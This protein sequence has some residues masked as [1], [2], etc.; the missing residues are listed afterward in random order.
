MEKMNG[1]SMN[2]EL[3]NIEKIGEIFP[4]VVTE[5]KVDFDILRTMLGEEVDTSKE[6]YQF[7]WNGKTESI[8]IA[9]APSSATLRPCRERS[10][11][12]DTTEN[13]YIEGDNLETL[14]QLQKTFFGKIKLIYIDPPYNTGN[15]FVYKDDFKDTIENYKEQTNQKYSSNAETS[16]RYHSDWL[17]MM[18]PR[19]ILARNLLTVD[20][21]IFIS[22]NDKELHNL[23]KM[24]EDIFGANNEVATLIWDKNHSAQAGIYKVYHE[25]V[26]VYARD[27]S[28][29]SKSKA[30]NSDVFEAGAMKKVS[31]RHPASEFTFPAGTRFDAP[32]GTIIEGE[33]GETEKVIITKGRLIA[34]NGVLKENVTL[35]AGFTQANQMRQFF[36]G[37]RDSLTDTQ[38][39]KIVEFYFNATG[40][41][42]VV[43]ERGV[44]TPQTTCKFGTQGAASTALAELFGLDETPF[45]SPKPVQMIKD[46]IGRFTNEQDIIID[47][48]SGSATTAHAVMELCM[49]KEE[50]RK[51]ILIQLPE[52][53]VKAREV[54]QKDAVRPIETA[55]GYLKAKKMELNLC[56]IGEERIRRAGEAIKKEWQQQKEKKGL[57]PG[58]A[59]P[60]DIGFKVFKLDSTNIN[61]WDNTKELDEQTLFDTATIFKPDRSKEDILYEI[62]LKYGVFDQ[63]TSEVDVNGKTMYRVGRRHM[64]VCLEDN[65][66]D[67][68]II[69]ICTLEP[70]VVVFKEDGFKD[71]NAKI[72][73][74]YNLKKAGV[75]DVKC[76]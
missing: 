45:S 44:E 68:D 4:N 46:F 28:K 55:I 5:G 19:L 60:I 75:E 65:I 71:D 49:E 67:E 12:W 10:K 69:E 41:I 35:K 50:K 43:K 23:K 14:K 58:E 74:E 56:S 29:I 54:A 72:N 47:F 21:M 57:L 27:A 63:S 64:I 36:Y 59:F 7:T 70:R 32:D 1:T 34:E 15:D 42:K 2:L 52:D 20:G 18:Y 11:D 17:N 31:G 3:E 13:M 40:K 8:K 51:Y 76:I 66:D 22:I 53:L 9:Q 39:Q 38:G 26:L 25:Y 33:Y 48:F 6:K 62:M 73:A 37:D 16:G 61:P 30:L 24:C